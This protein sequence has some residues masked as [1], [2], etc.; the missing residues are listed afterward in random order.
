MPDP[1]PALRASVD[2]VAALV[3]PL[4]DAV[5]APAYPAEWTIARVMSHL[6]SGAVIAERRLECALAGEQMEADFNQQ[7][8]KEWDAKSPR[9]MVDDG[10]DA[11]EAFTAR[12]EGVPAG[13]RGAITVS[14]GPL[15]LDWDQMV[16]FRLNE[17]VLHEWDIAVALDP[18]AGLPVDGVAHIVDNLDLVARFTA[19]PSG[20]SRTVTVRTLEP[21]RSFVVVIGSDAV[22]FS[23]AADGTDAEPA[24]T[25]PAESFIRLVYGRL[26]PQHTPSTV[27]GD[28]AALEQLRSVFPGP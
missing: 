17:H 28:A 16:R 26:D 23:T 12:L 8:W 27:D 11:D 7:V 10:L 25:M 3:R 15:T 21:E 20:E 14:L 18:A 2:R 19:K 6:G 5:T 22:Q 1:L 9:A 24:L 4:D 13:D